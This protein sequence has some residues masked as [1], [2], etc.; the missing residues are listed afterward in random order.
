MTSFMHGG[1]A[2]IIRKCGPIAYRMLSIG[3]VFVNI[4]SYVVTPYETSSW[5]PCSV[6]LVI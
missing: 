5:T 4:H 2:Y 3:H 1:T 6:P